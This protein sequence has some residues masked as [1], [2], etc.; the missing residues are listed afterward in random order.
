ML[1]RSV[2]LSCTES[3]SAIEESPS[4]R[5]KN[6]G[7]AIAGSR[8]LGTLSLPCHSGMLFWKSSSE[9]LQV[10]PNDDNSRFLEL[11]TCMMDYA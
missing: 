4:D 2:S 7:D 11:L 6:S 8:K 5:M 3:P 1:S 10:T 9:E